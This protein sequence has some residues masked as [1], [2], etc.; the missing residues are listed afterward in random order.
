MP[1]RRPERQ[2]GT[3]RQMGVRRQA[4]PTLWGCIHHTTRF[5]SSWRQQQLRPD[6]QPSRE[7]SSRTTHAF[8][9]CT[10]TSHHESRA[11][12]LPPQCEG[13]VNLTVLHNRVGGTCSQSTRITKARAPHLGATGES[14]SIWRHRS[15]GA[16]QIDQC[17]LDIAEGKCGARKLLS[18][19]IR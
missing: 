11:G 13:N 8:V 15:D 17:S 10:H 16:P 19:Q 9:P 1:R 3:L 7:T 6:R 4:T 2:I 12:C 5:V 14:S 18:D